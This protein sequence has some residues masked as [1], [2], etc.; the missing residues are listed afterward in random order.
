MSEKPDIRDAQGAR[1]VYTG[2]EPNAALTF[3]QRP[4]IVLLMLALWSIL[5]VLTET[6]TSSGLFL[7]DHRFGELALDGALGGF[8]LGWEG[9]PLA[10]LYIYCFRNP[11]RYVRVFFL[12]VI[13]MG[14]LAVSQVFHLATGDFSLESVVVPLAGSIALGAAA[15]VNVFKDRSEEELAAGSP[16]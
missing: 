11:D 13:H 6:F 8:A 14:A 9:I 5:G 15:F 1:A 7:E 10:A 4:R 2:A 12:A 16:K 3:L